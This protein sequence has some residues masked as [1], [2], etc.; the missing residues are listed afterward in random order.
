MALAEFE[1]ER[2]TVEDLSTRCLFC[3]FPESLVYSDAI[4]LE[5]AQEDCDFSAVNVSYFRLF[6]DESN[7]KDRPR[8]L[9]FYDF[10]FR[11]FLWKIRC[12]KFRKSVESSRR[13]RRR[14][15]RRQ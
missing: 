14:D 5:F 4:S 7:E 6:S 1:T 8:A 9:A 2:R 15:N 3:V 13:E 11:Y 10:F 12:G